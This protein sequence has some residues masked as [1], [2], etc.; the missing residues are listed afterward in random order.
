MILM[1]AFECHDSTDA[2][3]YR[4]PLRNGPSV[5]VPDLHGNLRLPTESW[6]NSSWSWAGQSYAILS[7]RWRGA[8]S[9]LSSQPVKGSCPGAGLMNLFHRQTR[10]PQPFFARRDRISRRSTHDATA[11]VRTAAAFKF[12]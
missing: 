6:D 11:I 3:C 7:A 9:M 5:R 1:R 4:P 8:G 2:P 12:R 10:E